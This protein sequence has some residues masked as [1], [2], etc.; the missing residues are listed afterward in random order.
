MT[1]K[2]SFAITYIVLSMVTVLKKREGTTLPLFAC[3]PRICYFLGELAV[4]H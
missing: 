4:W 2:Q 3:A 1:C